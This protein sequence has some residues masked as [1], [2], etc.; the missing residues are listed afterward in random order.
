MSTST[1]SLVGGVLLPREDVEL[2]MAEEFNAR[3]FLD[4][5]SGVRSSCEDGSCEDG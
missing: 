1:G 5:D 2:A 3:M 4:F